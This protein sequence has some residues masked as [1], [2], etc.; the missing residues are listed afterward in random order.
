MGRWLHRVQ[1][2]GGSDTATLPEEKNQKSVGHLPYKTYESPSV[3]SVGKAQDAFGENQKSAS[4]HPPKTPKRPLVG[5][6]GEVHGAFSEKYATRQE[7]ETMLAALR[8]VGHD[9]KEVEPLARTVMRNLTRA[10]AAEMA[11]VLDDL[12]HTAPTRDVARTQCRRVL[13]DPQ[14]LAA[15]KAVW[16]N[17][18]LLNDDEGDTHANLT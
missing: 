16:P 9:L 6:G 2:T 11:A 18:A 7:V 10:A 8:H 14:A 13:S 1:A 15:A 12:F 3:G 17:L 5:L 4:N